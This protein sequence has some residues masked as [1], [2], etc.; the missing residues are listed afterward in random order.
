MAR[1]K[2]TG[3]E[4]EMNLTPL[5][6]VVF[7]LIIFF[8]LVSNFVKQ[9]LEPTILLPQANKSVEEKPDDQHRLIVNVM[10]RKSGEGYF[11][12]RFVTYTTEAQLRAAIKHKNDATVSKR[13]GKVVM[14]QHELSN[15]IVKI[16]ADANVEWK[17]VQTVMKACMET[18][19]LPIWRLSFGVRPKVK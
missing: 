12:M 17:H 18:R 8:M 16:R 2:K 10:K 19:P 15:L 11:R 3:R 14:H 7:L 6:D 5:I 9:E 1:R 13:G 4:M